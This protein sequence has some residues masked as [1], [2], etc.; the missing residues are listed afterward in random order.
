MNTVGKPVIL[1]PETLREWE[2]TLEVRGGFW[3]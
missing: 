2:Q 3:E 1:I